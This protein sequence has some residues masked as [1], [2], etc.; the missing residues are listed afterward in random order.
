MLNVRAVLLTILALLAFAG[1]SL[2]CRMALAYTSMDAASFT[3][4]RLLSGALVLWLLV[5]L[6]SG[7]SQAQG[8]WLSALALFVYAAGFSFAYLQLNTGIG[9]LILFGAVQSGM[10]GY[11]LWRGERFSARQ[12]L[13]LLMA[14]AGLTGLLLPGL[15]APPLMGSMLMLTAGFAW[16][17]YSLRG[18]GAANPLQ[19]TAGN[20]IRTLPMTLLLS[21]VLFGQLSFDNNGMLYAVLSG[22][23]TSGVGYAIWYSVLPQLKATT[24]ATVQLTVPVL[25]AIAGIL[26]LSEPLTQRLILASVAILGGIALVVLT[27]VRRVK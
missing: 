8:S 20:F 23:L 15:S 6:R 11:G 10:I 1:N 21:V 25:A 14:C 5:A 4:V 9:A 18:K 16:A 2:L 12:W 7:S 3:T 19:V 13:G 27:P 17:V 26:I 22:A 24:A